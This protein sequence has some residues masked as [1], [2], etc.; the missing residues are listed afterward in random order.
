MNLSTIKEIT[1][2]TGSSAPLLSQRAFDLLRKQILEGEFKE[3]EKLNEAALQKL[4]GT[5]RSPIREAFRQLEMEGLIEMVP[6]RGAFVRRISP[7]DMREATEVRAI[8]ERLAV[9]LSAENI[10]KNFLSQLKQL[11]D[12]MDEK[13]ASG[14]TGAYTKLNYRF[15]RT[16]VEASKNQILMRLHAVVTEP[17]ISNHLTYI[18][19]MRFGNSKDNEHHEIYHLIKS[20]KTLKACNLVEKHAKSILSAFK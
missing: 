11:A 12:E 20:G 18:Y 19:L 4:L 2:K 3:G 14:E 1:G 17:F 5:S 16:I 8:L 13:A 10:S 9:Q 15:H 6:R 7:D